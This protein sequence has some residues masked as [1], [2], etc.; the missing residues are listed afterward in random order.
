MS[1]SETKSQTITYEIG[2]DAERLLLQESWRLVL[3]LVHIDM[4]QLERDLL[5]PER[6]RYTLG[7]G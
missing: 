6:R 5:L 7:A 3:A 1:V 2:Y 4:M